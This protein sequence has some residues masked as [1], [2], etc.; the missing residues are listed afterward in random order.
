MV[1]ASSHNRAGRIAGP[2][3]VILAELLIGPSPAASADPSTPPSP[4]PGHGIPA[5]G[6]QSKPVP[7]PFLGTP[8]LTE[9]NSPTVRSDA[10]G[11][12]FRVAGAGFTP[13]AKFEI[14]VFP[15]TGSGMHCQV[16][17]DTDQNGM[18]QETMADCVTEPGLTGA[19]SYVLAHDRSSKKFSNKLLVK[20]TNHGTGLVSGPWLP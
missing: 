19:D 8:T 20:A 12:P 1:K 4:P 7:Q 9:S 14:R 15:L 10:P 11:E 6:G 3:I 16:L 13:N 5:I 2:L 17:D 18:F